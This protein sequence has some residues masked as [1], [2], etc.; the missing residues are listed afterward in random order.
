MEYSI[1]GYP[2][3]AILLLLILSLGDLALGHLAKKQYE[4]YTSNYIIY[5]TALSGSSTKPP[6]SSP[7]KVIIK[8]LGI[9]IICLIWLIAASSGIRATMRLYWAIL[10]FALTIYFV[11]DLRH[12]ESILIGQLVKSR[13]D[14][15]SGKLSIKR[16]FSLG[17]TAIQLLT[18]S[19]IMFVVFLFA[20]EPFFIGAALAPLSLLIRNLALLRS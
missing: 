1:L 17:Q 4:R 3:I 20:W 9:A 11:I 5:E 19:V 6:R 8:L 16:G 10:G 12:L 7:A 2:V 18:L 14:Q 15:L 13:G